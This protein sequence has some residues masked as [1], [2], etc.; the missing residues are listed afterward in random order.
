MTKI[1]K[2][3]G[4]VIVL[5]ASLAFAQKNSPPARATPEV[6]PTDAACTT[7]KTATRSGGLAGARTSNCTPSLSSIPTNPKSALGRVLGQIAGKNTPRPGR[8]PDF[9][10]S[11]N[12]GYANPFH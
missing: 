11:S 6:R 2:M 12:T 7:G 9:V 4:R 8:T 3:L 1:S 5:I 10:D